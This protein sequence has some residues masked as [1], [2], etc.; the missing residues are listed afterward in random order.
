MAVYTNYTSRA[1]IVGTSGA[2]SIYNSGSN[3]TI[4]AGAG[5]DTINNNEDYVTIDAGAGN[6]TIYNWAGGWGDSLN[7]GEGDDSVYSYWRTTLVAGDGDDLLTVRAGHIS[8]GGG[9]DTIR[10]MGRWKNYIL[11]GG[12]GN[13]YFEVSDEESYPFYYGRLFRYKNG[14]GNDTITAA[15]YLDT[16]QIYDG[17]SFDTL[18]A[19]T[20]LL[21][22][23]GS[24]SIRVLNMFDSDTSMPVIYSARDGIYPM[25]LVNKNN[26]SVVNGNALEDTIVNYGARAT[27]V[28]DKGADVIDNAGVGAVVLAGDGDDSIYGAAK[29]DLS[30][31]DGGDG[32]DIFNISSKNST[33]IGGDGD[34][35]ITATSLASGIAILGGAG[36]DNINNAG[37]NAVIDAG[38][39]DDQIENSGANAQVSGGDDNDL[40]NNFGVGAT[41]DGGK[42]NDTINNYASLAAINGGTEDDY[43]FNSAAKVQIDG[44]AGNDTIKNIG[45]D[46]KSAT[47]HGGA[48]NDTI[49]IGSTVQGNVI[50]YSEGD[51]NDVIQNFSKSD[52]LKFADGLDVSGSKNG[53]DYVLT[54]KGTNTTGNTIVL[55]GAGDYNFSIANGEVKVTETDDPV[56]PT[57]WQDVLISSS[58]KEINLNDAVSPGLVNAGGG[59]HVVVS[60][61]NVEIHSSE[62]TDS[63]EGSDDYGE[64]FIFDGLGGTDYFANFNT[65]DTIKVDTGY[66]S[67]TSSYAKG[68]DYIINVGE[69]GAQIVLV[70]AAYLANLVRW[71]EDDKGNQIM[72]I[73]G[74]NNIINRTNRETVTGTYNR[75]YIINTGNNV[76]INGKGGDDTIVSS[77]LYGEVIQFAATDGNDLVKNFGAGD[78]LQITSGTPS[79]ATVGEDVVVTV[80][81]NTYVGKITLE[82]AAKYNFKKSG[83]YY[84]ID[85][86]NYITNQ[87]DGVKVT[88]TDGRD[89]I[90][91]SGANATIQAGKG[92]DTLEGSNFG[93]VFAFSSADGNDVITN[94]GANDTL[95]ITAGSIV[96]G[97]I[98]GDD[99]VVEVKG[100]TQN[101]KVTLKDA[102]GYLW[103]QTTRKLTV[104]SVNEIVNTS[105]GVKVTG[106]GGV[107]YIINS[108]EH[109]TIQA[110]GGNDTIEGSDQYGEVFAFSS[111][112][113]D[114]VITNFGKG[115]SLVMTTGKTMSFESLDSGEYLVKLKGSKYEGTVLLQ[116]D[117]GIR[118]DYT[119]VQTGNTLV[120][121]FNTEIVNSEDGVKV[122]GTGGA[123]YITNS[124]QNVTI[125]PNAG[126]DTLEGS[127][128]A[129]LYQFSSA[130][131]DNV[132][133]NFGKGDTLQMTTGKTMSYAQVDSDVV[134]TLAGKSYTGTVTLKDV[135]M[136]D[137]D[138]LSASK[139]T[140]TTVSEITNTEDKKKVLGTSGKDYIIN[141]GD[142][143][144][145]QSGGGNDTIEGSDQFG[146]VFAFSSADGDNVITN[147]GLGDTLRCTAGS[148]N[149]IA[150][151][152][153]DIV[154]TLKGTSYTGTVTL[155][156]AAASE[157]FT[158]SQSGR[159]IVAKGKGSV[160]Y[161]SNDKRV[162]SGT[163]DDEIIVN[164]GQNVTIEGKG[165]NDTIEGSD[166][167][168][169]VFV[170]SAFDGNDV[171]T[172][173]GAGDSLKI[174][175]T[176]QSTLANGNALTITVKDEGETGTITLQNVDVTKVMQ[177]DGA[178]VY[179]S[180]SKIINRT[181]RVK[182][183]GTSLR[184]YILNT[185]NNVTLNGGGGD[186]TI[187]GSNLYKELYQFAADGGHDYIKNFGKDDTLQITSGR[188][189]GMEA[190]G[191][192]MIV[193]VKSNVQSGTV[194]LGGAAGF[195]FGGDTNTLGTFLTVTSESTLVNRDDDV[196]VTGTGGSDYIINSGQNVTIQ[197][198][199]GAD[200]IEGSNFG[201]V[202]AFSSA[203]GNDVITNFGANDTLKITAGTFK[204]MTTVGDDVVV[205]VQGAKYSGTVTLQDA[206]G[207]NLKR[208][209]SNIYVDNVN[210][211]VNTEDG[212][213]VTGSGGAD[214]IVTTGE[215]VTVQ[216]NGGSDTIT[217]SDAYSEL[218]NFSSA[219]GENVITNFSAG[220]SIR[221]TTGKTMTWSKSGDDVL[222]SL[223][224]ATK[225]GS[226]L[227]QGAAGLNFTKSGNVLTAVGVNEIVNGYDSI[228]VVG[229]TGRDYIYNSG[230]GVS[231]QGGSGDD[232][233]EGSTFAETFLF[234]S[235]DGNDVITN[236]G[237]NDTLKITA[238]TFK[239][240]TT[241]GDDVVVSVK[242]S[243][244]SGTVTLQDAASLGLTRSGT[245]I[246][247]KGIKQIT[248]TEDK[249]IV[250]G[251]SGNDYIVNTGE[252]VTLRGAAGNDT[253]TGSDE[254]GDVFA[255]SSADGN[256]V[257]TN[258]SAN[259]TLRCT[260]GSIKA[261]AISGDDYVLTLKGTNYTGTVTLQGAATDGNLIVSA[262]NKNAY[263]LPKVPSVIVFDAAPTAEEYWF[264]TDT[265]AENDVDALMS[266]AEASNAIGKL[267]LE[268]DE[269]L[270]AIEDVSKIDRT[271]TTSA[272][273]KD[274]DKK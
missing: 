19:G 78:T 235:A 37:A 85:D 116:A 71:T 69:Y 216:S 62:L 196:K 107:D 97:S 272:F 115:D 120:A 237:A 4:S 18:Q 210:Q 266:E 35:Y 244:Y 127:D 174:D 167:Y 63:I 42:G 191:T 162:V 225:E 135:S 188:I 274:K 149:G 153:N 14:D 64:T 214:Y 22:T 224:G 80:K 260:A 23:V 229:S 194:T 166:D 125:A 58:N 193:Y 132:I 226:I 187:V 72:S 102:G 227:L 83:D 178:F 158:I 223:K 154:V 31:Y 261:T 207:L 55:Q 168:G 43:I 11:D 236:F 81:S 118:N 47:I 88:G 247:V 5:N 142:K 220:D 109:V 29:A 184:D 128:Y 119:L 240:M 82:G 268:S 21:I 190:S 173:F 89:Y 212:V 234:S 66:G 124:G 181:N 141:T 197:G 54:V 75:D 251:T 59:L 76:V 112:D 131:G 186:D 96:G 179:D 9:N 222:V 239:S 94:F 8:A 175:G 201:E 169:E 51:G 204:S 92:N 205:S 133:L 86:V 273:N 270:T 41:L 228:K 145:V 230:Q 217:G 45:D 155:K 17:S 34:D 24:G 130:D 60:G 106:T 144:T 159:N 114:N 7:A 245:S 16:I 136:A 6:D 12:T 183:T 98:I 233:I 87:N 46:A 134:V 140:Y 164:S 103:N 172:N 176:V 99:Y 271:L 199:S 269:L 105:D 213:K 26:D 100:A 200:T 151:V 110:N 264:E 2:D 259:D 32:N 27:L 30:T 263:L 28:G 257:I 185:G 195:N 90:T 147:F 77:K 246:Y 254:Y 211:I 152:G 33:I 206:A 208:N 250:E 241:V 265:A 137:L 238:G 36:A 121:T 39:G 177:K 243:K 91:N 73:D 139:L 129:E 1:S 215:N 84:T 242:G 182:V 108:G 161:N 189:T 111:A 57:E 101:G 255:F 10:V 68:D 138:T 126:N 104:Q 74:V 50:T 170:F 232:T 148:I 70:G 25:Y 156:D 219:D 163:D 67:V 160:V 15:N 198:G 52:V 171:I 218:F 49:V 221:M 3:V 13:D 143:V 113:G 38:A 150:T 122:T 202:F 249:K 65:N 40:I 146:E 253:L 165:G 56:L 44:G 53:S 180:E 258:F 20:D 209:G 117:N 256:N 267:T 61:S 262:N 93:E 48:G 231:I 252:N 192:D 123:D 79:M 248:N 157:L 95:N 203:D